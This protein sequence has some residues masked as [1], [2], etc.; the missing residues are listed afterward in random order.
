MNG[1]PE[2]IQIAGLWHNSFERTL[3][4]DNRFV[5]RLRSLLSSAGAQSIMYGTA[6]T[7]NGI[8]EGHGLRIAAQDLGIPVNIGFAGVISLDTAGA[9]VQ[10]D[11]LWLTVV[12]P[13][14]AN[15]AA[16]RREWKRWLDQHEDEIATGDSLL[17]AN[18][19]RSVPNLSSICLLTEA[20][21]RPVLLTGD[22]RSDHLLEG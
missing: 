9:P 6:I 16:P 21:G 8:A 4:P 5:P 17:M 18:S 10:F 15:L 2:L 12:G 14:R 13:T 20:Y 11:N 22:A 19:D 3:D 7:V 1:D